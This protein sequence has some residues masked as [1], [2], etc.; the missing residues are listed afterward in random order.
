MRN[1]I[2]ER[3]GELSPG[4]IRHKI[5][6]I[7]GRKTRKAA[8]INIAGSTDQAQLVISLSILPPPSVRLSE[9]LRETFRKH[10]SPPRF[11]LVF[12][13]APSPLVRVKKKRKNSGTR[14][15]NYAATHRDI[16]G[17]GW[18][19]IPYYTRALLRADTRGRFVI[20]IPGTPLLAIPP[21]LPRRGLSPRFPGSAS[22]TT[23]YE[24]HVE[25]DDDPPERKVAR[26]RG[27]DESPSP[28]PFSRVRFSFDRGGSIEEVDKPCRKSSS[29]IFSSFLLFSLFLFGLEEV[30]GYGGG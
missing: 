9:G 27:L 8:D 28:P 22:F 17:P 2:M 13:P 18:R 15:N 20:N 19:T 5:N 4:L 23:L 14:A 10:A 3:R 21:R 30:E 1:C 12:H 24:F 11:R 26:R 7:A 6:P 16:P 29:W 25:R